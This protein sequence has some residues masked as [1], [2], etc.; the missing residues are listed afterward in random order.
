MNMMEQDRD[1]LARFDAIWGRVQPDHTSAGAKQEL[2]ARAPVSEPD[3]AHA[4]RLMIDRTCVA[5]KVL[6]AIAQREPCHAARLRMLACERR[7]MTR[8]LQGAYYLLTGERFVP[9]AS[10]AVRH[11]SAACLRCVWQTSRDQAALAKRYA[12]ETDE[13]LLQTLYTELAEMLADQCEALQT[14]VCALLK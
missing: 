6:A 9:G 10:C 13:P 5:A 14:I 8:Q 7:V 1:V 2:P 4:L 3:D 12:Q 11:E